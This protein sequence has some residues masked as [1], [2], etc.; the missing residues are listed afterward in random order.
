[1]TKTEVA[2]MALA[3]LGARSLTDVD[4]DTTP[5]AITVRKFYNNTR[6]EALRVHPW[7]FAM[8]R[9]YQEVTW[10]ALSGA[11]VTASGTLYK[12]THTSHGLTT[13][14]RIEIKEATGQTAVNA[15]WRITRIDADNFTLDDSTYASGYTSGTGSWLKIPEF[16]WTR[17]HELP[18][19]SL[20][21]FRMNGSDNEEDDSEHFEIEGSYLL[22]EADEIELRYVFDQ[23]DQTKWTADFIS[24][25][26]TLLA[27]HIS[28]DI[29]GESGDADALLQRYEKLKKSTAQTTDSRESKRRRQYPFDDADVIRARRGFITVP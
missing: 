23:T 25:F 14:E 24:L 7:N 6:Q 18:S 16:G 2:N 10:T 15:I 5:Q 12:V 8:K 26:T 27:A 17:R 3:L 20:R 22:C 29:H 19:D 13:G 9:K 1:M 4:A 28:H 21:V 11:A